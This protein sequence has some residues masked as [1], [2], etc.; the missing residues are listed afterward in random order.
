MGSTPEPESFALVRNVSLAYGS[1]TALKNVT[2][3]INRSEVHA[4]VGEHG[5]GKS[6]LAH[7]VSGFQRPDAGQIVLRRRPF[8]HL[9]PDIARENGIHAIAQ[10]N[11]LFDDFSV[12]DNIVIDGSL[13]VFPFFTSASS[14]RRRAGSSR[15]WASASTPRCRSAP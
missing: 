12:A 8:A 5:A 13:G 1:V 15:G 9:T 10:H 2:L 14:T 6:S 4:I 11:P 7:V 3:A